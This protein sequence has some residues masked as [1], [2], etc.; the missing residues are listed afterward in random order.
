MSRIR[1]LELSTLFGGIARSRAYRIADRAEP[2][3]YDGSTLWL[4]FTTNTLDS[5][6]TF[7][8][9]TTATYINA[10]GYV[11]SAA[12]NTPRF[13]Y[14]PTTFS[15]EGLLIEAQTINYLPYSQGLI[16]T[17]WS[18]GGICTR[19]AN[20][21][22]G[23]DGVALSA[24]RLE[25]S[26]SG[27]EGRTYYASAYTTLPHT[28]SIWLKS[29]TGSN[30]TVRLWNTSGT[31]V[32]CTVTPTWQRFSSVSV[33]GTS[34]PGYFYLE[35]PSTTTAVDILAWGAQLEAGSGVSS[36]IPTTTSTATR[37]A[38]FCSIEDISSLAYSTTAG[39]MLYVGSFTKVNSVSYP[40]RAGFT[41]QSTDER[42][43]GFLTNSLGSSIEAKGVGATPTASVSQSISTN[44]EYKIA[45]SLNTALSTG[46]VRK[47]SNGSAVS[48]SGA[49]ALT[50]TGSPTYF[51]FGQKGYELYFPSGTIKT[52]KYWPT[53]LDDLTIQGLTS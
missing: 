49:T 17:G 30:Q 38:D 13:E 20:Y 10:Q 4:D 29:N 26:Y 28:T 24:T 12:V 35:N 14:D 40:W 7:T 45:W 41:K 42:T 33:F 9:S 31:P 50:A 34:L 5:R 48:V 8:R 36:Y 53:T 52:F 18:T 23:P 27:G 37:A 11:T 39:S 46:E 22:T 51:M 3:D 6:C 1:V 19:T 15:S 43:F 25:M 21:A 47:S 16:G 32:S 44:T 2:L